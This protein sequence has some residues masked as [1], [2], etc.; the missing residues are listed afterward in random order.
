MWKVVS[1]AETYRIEVI[2][3]H[4]AMP[5]EHAVGEPTPSQTN[6]CLDLAAMADLDAARDF[7]EW[8]DECA[9]PIEQP[10]MLT[11]W[12][13][14]DDASSELHIRVDHLHHRSCLPGASR[15][16]LHEPD[17]LRRI[18]RMSRARS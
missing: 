5:D 3:E 10:K 18:Q 8:T 16:R 2:R 4:D 11:S 12:R 9:S 14:N 7:D 1:P 15:I 6:E 13:S 17:Q